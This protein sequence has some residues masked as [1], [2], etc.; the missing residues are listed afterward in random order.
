MVFSI[1]LANLQPL[2]PNGLVQVAAARRQNIIDGEDCS[3]LDLTSLITVY[4][5]EY[6]S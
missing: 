2:Y 1:M 6:C 4:S 5:L 3:E